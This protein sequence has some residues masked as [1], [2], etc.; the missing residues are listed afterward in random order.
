MALEN[1]TRGQKIFMVTLI[2]ILAGMFTITGAM[3]ALFNQGG[4]T[5]PPDQ[6]RIDGEAVRLMDFQR[7]RRALGIVQALDRNSTPTSP[8]APEYMYA[9]VPTMAVQAQ[10]GH[11]WP[12]NA[13]RPVPTSLLDIWPHYQDQQIWC[14]MILA[15]RAR[16]NGLASL[17]EYEPGMED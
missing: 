9:R 10:A 15:K 4:K 5:A 3:L 12:Y 16:L 1:Y 2:V 14:H 6:G 8:D 17:G 13:Q 7:K 11:D